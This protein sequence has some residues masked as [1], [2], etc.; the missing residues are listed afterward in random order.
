[1]MG[2]PAPASGVG[3]WVH[4]TEL[5][6]HPASVSGARGFVAMRLVEH[7]VEHLVDDVQLVVS[8]LATN[9]IVHADTSFVVTLRVCE[10][11]VRLEVDDGSH[12]QPV[13]TTARTLDT[14]GRGIAIVDILSRD[15]GVTRHST[16]GKSVWAEFAKHPA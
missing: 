7:A 1:M 9:A 2:C 16:R 10:D 11:S 4:T 14:G 12:S 8:E 6:A 13:L 3:G 15:W 5:A